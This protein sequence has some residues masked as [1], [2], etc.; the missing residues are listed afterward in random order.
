[1]VY[2]IELY[3]VVVYIKEKY[4]IVG[5]ST[6]NCSVVQSSRM[7]GT[8]EQNYRPL[9]FQDI[10]KIPISFVYLKTSKSGGNWRDQQPPAPE[11]VYIKKQYIVVM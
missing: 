4:S 7:L 10:E 11:K 3:S 6:E 5:C 2:S 9:A 8:W 1:M